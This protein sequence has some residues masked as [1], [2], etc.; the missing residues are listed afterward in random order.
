MK[1]FAD[2]L[3]MVK[4]KKGELRYL[5]Q[6]FDRYQQR[7]Y[8]YFI[9]CTSD[10]TESQDLT[11]ITFMRV[12]KY[13]HS[14]DAQ[15]TFEVWLFGI[16]RN[17]VRDH[18]KKMKVYRDQF[19]FA[20]HL[21]DKVEDE[22]GL[23]IENEARLHRALNQMDP[24]KRELLVMA[25]FQGIKYEQI[26]QIRGST[27]AAIKVQVHRAIAKLREYYFELEQNEE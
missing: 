13:R 19:A 23:N 2:E 4:V 1:A 7:L 10:W 14:F 20:E 26:A 8:N 15:K 12:M 27:I 16:A 11:Q 18:F 6:L 17:L 24:D 9:K 3:L 5:E 21:P 22:D 25:K